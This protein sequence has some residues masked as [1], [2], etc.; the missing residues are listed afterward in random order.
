MSNG[1][2][3]EYGGQYISETLMNE[4][5]YLEEQYN[6]YINDPEKTCVTS[7]TWQMMILHELLKDNAGRALE[8][9]ENYQSKFT[10][11]EAYFASI[12]RLDS[13]GERIRYGADKNAN[14]DLS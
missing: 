14:V 10:S 11:K 13:D 8:I 12:D 7:A 1:R 2:Y 9:I 6:Y 5:L 3:G 4:L